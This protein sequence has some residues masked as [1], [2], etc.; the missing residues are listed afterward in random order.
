MTQT[1][2]AVVVAAGSG[3]RLGHSIPKALVPLCG[4]PILFY[5][6]RTFCT[7]PEFSNIILV[8]SASMLEQTD[9]FLDR[10]PDFK[11]KVKVVEGGDERWKSV[12]NGV[13]VSDADWVAIHDAA[14]PFVTHRVIDSVLEKRSEY[15]CVI[16]ATPEVDT[17][18][19]FSG[20]STGETIDRS[21]LLRVGT[22]QLFRRDLLVSSFKK[23]ALMSPA[24]TDEAALMELEGV[25][26]GFSWGDPLNFKITTS[27]DL[28]IA[29]ALLER[30]PKMLLG[31]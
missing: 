20:N 11:S 12:R 31:G 19:T 7:H 23:A 29:E 6:L 8:V 30:N 2:D 9:L 15:G 25:R 5:S 26:V 27:A 16:T 22:P 3:T 10:Y 18:R 13:V 28:F 1:F 21:K 14:R 24:P 17:I 4:N